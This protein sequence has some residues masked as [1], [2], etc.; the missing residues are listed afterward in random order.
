MIITRIFAVLSPFIILGCSGQFQWQ[1]RDSYDEVIKKMKEVTGDNCNIKHSPE[2]HIDKHFISHLPDI[3]D[4][5]INPVF[6]N[7]TAL[8]H[9]HN[10]ALSRAF[11]YSFILQRAPDEK[12]PGFMYYYLSTISDIAANPRINASAIYFSPNMSYTPS[13]KGF[14][15]KTLP[16]FAPRAFRSD[17]FNDPIHLQRISTLNTFQAD[18][19]GA[20]RSSRSLNYTTDQYRINEW[21][22][23]WLPDNTRRQDSKITY[24]VRITHANNTNETFDW[25]GPPGADEV[26]GPVKWTRPYFDCERSNK[27]MIAAT[28][29]IPDVYP[30]HTQFRHI[31]YPTYVAASV[32]EMDFDR[33][34]IN[35]CPLGEGNPQPNKFAGTDR[36]KHSTTECE[37]IH[38][39]G[40]R[41]GGYQCRCKPGYRLPTNVR[42]P[43]LGEII[44]RGTATEY[45]KLFECD[46]IGYTMMMPQNKEKL[47]EETRRMYVKKYSK[48]RNGTLQEKQRNPKN[49]EQFLQFIRKGVTPKTCKDKRLFSPNDLILDGD[50]GF[51]VEKQFENEARMALRLANF[52]S[53]FLQVVDPNELFAELRLADKPLTEDQ[54][55]GEALSMVMGNVKIWGAGIFWDTEKFPNRTLFAPYAYK[56]EENTRKFLAEDLTRRILTEPYVKKKWFSHLKSRWATSAEGLEEYILKINIRAN[57]DGEYATKYDHFPI[58]FRGPNLEHGYWTSPYYDCGFHN[59]WIVTYAAPFFGWDDIR[60]NLEFYGVVTV[61]S[62]ITKLDINQCSDDYWVQNAFK[63]THKCERRSSMCVPILGRGFDSGGYKCECEQGYEYPFDNPITYFDGQLMEAEYDNLIKDRASWF[64]MFGCRIAAANY[65]CASVI[66]TFA[67]LLLLHCLR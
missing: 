55:F 57:Q 22:T 61:S 46:P 26:P 30:R 33:I 15:N 59:Q 12:E 49:I 45:D 16:L 52:I 17:D 10:M 2:L 53:G 36:C 58:R 4:I 18:D 8:L 40:L 42:R 7:R 1:P 29:P 62:P 23:A 41:R 25:H 56:T 48:V 35:Q 47:D 66:I 63:G 28:V 43:Y 11:F 9:A 3:K 19:L 14:F 38:G 13:Y 21:Y 50:I 44:E 65:S 54:M 6:P 64:D 24:T 34:D 39:Y 67:L 31:E 5:N 60:T 51:G 37:P 32:M 27:W 20:F